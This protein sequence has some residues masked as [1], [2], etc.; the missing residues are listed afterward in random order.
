MDKNEQRLLAAAEAN[1]GLATA[2]KQPEPAGYDRHA[3]GSR[4]KRPRRQ[5]VRRRRQKRKSPTTTEEDQV[6]L[7]F[8]HEDCKTT[9]VKLPLYT[10]AFPIRAPSWKRSILPTLV[11][12]K[13]ISAQ[14]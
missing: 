10:K 9:E 5:A 11:P 8:L 6:S 1:L 14:K 3:K 2:P 7:P 13:V 12:T 4:A